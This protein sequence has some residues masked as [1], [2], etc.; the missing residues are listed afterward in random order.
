MSL[1]LYTKP[2]HGMDDMPSLKTFRRRMMIQ[3]TISHKNLIR[4]FLYMNLSGRVCAIVHQHTAW[5]S[6]PRP[7]HHH[8]HRSHDQTARMFSQ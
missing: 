6:L 8:H 5:R 3:Y 4:R 1:A 7:H 2:A